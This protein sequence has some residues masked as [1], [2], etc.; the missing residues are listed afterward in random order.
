MEVSDKASFLFE[1]P[2]AVS[3]GK[4]RIDQSMAGL[5]ILQKYSGLFQ[6][7]ARKKIVPHFARTG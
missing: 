5:R 4:T 6:A 7:E 1:R 2:R 3:R